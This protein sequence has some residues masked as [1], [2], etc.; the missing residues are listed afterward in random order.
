[1]GASL[2]VVAVRWVVFDVVVLGGSDDD[3]LRTVMN[4]ARPGGCK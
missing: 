4:N 2:C 3:S 1:V